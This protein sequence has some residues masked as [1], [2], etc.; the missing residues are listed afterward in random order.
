MSRIKGDSAEEKAID[1]L[2]KHKFKIVQRNFYAKKL[3]EI[4]IISK[5]DDIYHFIEVKSGETY[6]AVY[7]ITPSKLRKIYN[8]INY[9]LKLNDIDTKYCID[10]IIVHGK[11]I[12]FLENISM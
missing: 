4:D 5:K 12:D 8:S 9:Y 10:A 6:D 3:G 7:N 11:N 2:I 1:F